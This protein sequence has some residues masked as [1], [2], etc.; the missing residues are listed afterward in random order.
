MCS[1]DLIKTLTWDRLFVLFIIGYT[2][3]KDN[4]PAQKG[5]GMNGIS[6]VMLLILVLGLEQTGY[7]LN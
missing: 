1:S 7:R 5:D 4:L 3:T 6:D 2:T